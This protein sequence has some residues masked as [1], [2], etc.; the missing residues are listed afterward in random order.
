METEWAPGVVANYVRQFLS[1]KAAEGD[2]EKIDIVMT[3]D[4]QGVSHHK[5]HIA[6]F[7]GVAEVMRS[8]QI[9][10]ELYTLIT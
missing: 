3:F 10:F 5:N 8:H 2:D 6:C 7:Q 4:D 1:K 9:E